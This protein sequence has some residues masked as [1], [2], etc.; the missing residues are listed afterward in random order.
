MSLKARAVEKIERSGISNYAFDDDQLILCGV[1][2]ALNPCACG[3]PDCD[4]VAL[5]RV[6]QV[7]SPTLQ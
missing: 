7:S 5:Q 4:G 3:A 2:Y 6:A 1:R